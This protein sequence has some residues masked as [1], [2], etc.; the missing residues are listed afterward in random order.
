[1]F[2]LRPYQRE[3]VDAIFRYF[4]EGND[5][6]PLVCCP[7]ASGKSVI[8]SAFIRETLAQWPSERFLLLT[9]VKEL[10]EQNA[11]KIDFCS[12]GIYSAGLGK[13]ET[14][15]QVTIAGIQSV[16]NK[17]HELGDISIV[18][19]DEAHTIPKAGAGMYRTFFKSLLG[20]CPQ[21][22]IIGLTA[23]PFRLDSGTLHRG[24]DRIFTDIAYNIDLK[25]LIDECF[26][27][28]IRSVKTQKVIDTSS[29]KK[30]GG[31][32]ITGEL[33]DFMNRDDITGPALNEAVQLLADRKS[34]IVFCVSVEH[35]HD[36][37]AKLNERGIDSRVVVGDTPKKERSELIKQFKSREFRAL[38]SVGILTVGFDAPCVDA[39]VCLR[40]TKSVG[41]WVQMCGRGMRLYPDK[42][43][44]VVCDFT[45]NT[46]EHGP[47]NLINIDDD[48]EVKTSPYRVC[49]GCGEM[50]EPRLKV[51]PSCGEAICKDC[52]QCAAL[53]PLGVMV[54]GSCGYEYPEHKREINH[55]T[56]ANGGNI[57][58]DNSDNMVEVV[59]WLPR[60]HRKEGKPD[61]VR[62]TYNLNIKDWICPA[63]GGY[64]S[65]KARK[66]WLSRGGLVPAPITAQEA[67]ARWGELSKPQ[68][69]LVK[70][71][72]KYFNVERIF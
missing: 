59:Q 71:N 56:R 40:P 28:P 11:A 51:C 44:C 12:V 62:I 3:C 31:E 10:L 19:V 26:L 67:V 37:A 47:I 5:G 32:Y 30:R 66:F 22:K 24:K 46:H 60:I 61:S 42:I 33:S 27:S 14:G 8:Q 65:D 16:F 54:C 25:R 45:Q 52:P 34:W 49:S 43:D 55:D 39:L 29:V 41:L 4:E 57:I 20:I 58:A 15:Y 50:V 23:T 1:M 72:G 2:E 63:H 53:V 48:G 38:V 64:A 36:V 13:K 7:T 6:N 18:I 70:K 35:A 21:V 69:I 9:H 68:K 17:A